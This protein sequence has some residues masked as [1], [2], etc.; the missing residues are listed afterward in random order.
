M[1]MESNNYLLSHNLQIAIQGLVGELVGLD[2]VLNN[3]KIDEGDTITIATNRSATNRRNIRNICQNRDH[4]LATFITVNESPFEFLRHGL[5]DNFQKIGCEGIDLT[6]ADIEAKDLFNKYMSKTKEQILSKFEQLYAKEREK[7]KEK[8]EQRIKERKKENIDDDGEKYKTNITE[9][10]NT[11]SHKDLAKV[12]TLIEI[13]KHR[14]LNTS[15]SLNTYSNYFLR[16]ETWEDYDYDNRRNTIEIISEFANDKFEKWNLFSSVFNC[17]TQT[18][19]KIDSMILHYHK[20]MFRLIM[21]ECKT[22]KSSL[23]KNQK[24][25]VECIKQIKSDKVEYKVLYL[26]YKMPQQLIVN[27]MSY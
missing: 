2:F 22:G 24:A 1:Y 13:E 20:G 21:I 15:I 16:E 3:L 17:I 5:I 19:T 10:I 8:W 7:A 12:L 27:E 14:V 23:T 6:N 25:F 4:P 11:L 26:D 18:K 9:I